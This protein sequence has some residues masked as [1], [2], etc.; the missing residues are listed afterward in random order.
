ML[1]IYCLDPIELKQPDAAFS[2]E[3]DACIKLGVG[4]KL[5]DLDALASNKNEAVRKI[6]S[7]DQPTIG[8]Y[9]GWMMRSELYYDFYHALQEKGIRLIN[10][11]EQYKKCHYLPES[12]QTIKGMTPLTVWVPK[13]RIGD[14]EFVF[15]IAKSLGIGPGI[16]KDYVKSQ[17]HYWNEAC[18]IPSMTDR[19]EVERVTRRFLELQG[20]DLIGG[21]VFR[22]Y[23]E[24]DK[25]GY[26][27]ESGMP[28]S[29]EFRIFFLEGNPLQ[30]IRYWDELEYAD[31][32]PVELFLEVA[33]KVESNFFSMDIAKTAHG[34]WIIVELGDGQVSDL[35]GLADVDGFYKELVERLSM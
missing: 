12:Y 16:V 35:P 23:V 25:V 11:P 8:V 3:V 13:E 15:Q 24:L 2:T 6:K 14:F 5:I 26:H 9:R 4:F 19:S 34:E 33:R 17:K 7:L 1:M 30:T 27:P 32:P 18:F 28:V 22:E 20:D 21:L 31:S 10:N 29:R